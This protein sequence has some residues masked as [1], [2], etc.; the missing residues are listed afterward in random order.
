[1]GE[2]LLVRHIPKRLSEGT[3]FAEIIHGFLLVD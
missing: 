3:R 2:T 1:V